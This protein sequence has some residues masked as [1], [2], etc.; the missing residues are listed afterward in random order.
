[1]A[2]GALDEATGAGVGV[3]ADADRAACDTAPEAAGEELAEVGLERLGLVGGDILNICRNNKSSPKF[4]CCRL[5]GVEPGF[6]DPTTF[7]ALIIRVAGG[8]IPVL[9]AGRSTGDVGLDEAE[10]A[11][12]GLDC[13]GCSEAACL[14]LVS[15][16]ATFRSFA[17]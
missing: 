8:L 13:G 2:D 12:F 6:I 1:M 5:F 16:V 17:I 14:S 7:R 9:P 11:L 15:V 3:G 10:V 4:T